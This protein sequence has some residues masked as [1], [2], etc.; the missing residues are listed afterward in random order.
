[1]SLKALFR[2]RIKHERL[3]IEVEFVRYNFFDRQRFSDPSVVYSVSPAFY[4]WLL[5]LF[6]SY[7][8]FGYLCSLSCKEWFHLYVSLTYLSFRARNLNEKQRWKENCTEHCERHSCCVQLCHSR[9]E[10]VVKLYANDD[11]KSAIRENINCWDAIAND[12]LTL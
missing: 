5:K 8:S 7:C 9:N 4:G 12:R 10:W 11:F 6:N 2:K 1:M 3:W